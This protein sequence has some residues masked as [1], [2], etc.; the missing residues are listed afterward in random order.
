MSKKSEKLLEEALTL[1]PEE[2][3]EVAATLLESL[4]EQEDEAV[5]EAWVME[6]EKR[7]REVE[8]GHVKTVP[9]SEVRRRLRKAINAQARS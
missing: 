4:D 6:I 2:R 1:T 7:I 9:W 8:S 5:E 3:A